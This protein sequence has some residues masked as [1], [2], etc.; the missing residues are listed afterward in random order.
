[1][2][3]ATG[4]RVRG[5][6]LDASELLLAGANVAGNPM[7]FPSIALGRPRSRAHAPPPGRRR[8][9]S[10][11]LAPTGR[12]RG[13][14]GI[15]GS[16]GPSQAAAQSAKS[17]MRGNRLRRTCGSI[18]NPCAAASR[19]APRMCGRATSNSCQSAYS[20]RRCRSAIGASISRIARSAR[21]GRVTVFA[22]LYS[23]EPPAPSAR[24]R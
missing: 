15:R 12:I 11:S 13:F 6:S 4:Q 14:Q 18:C 19:S 21:S 24:A 22:D 9:C 23:R 3:G 2:P 17:A 16:K 20:G 5:D 7:R 8:R 1:V 10:R